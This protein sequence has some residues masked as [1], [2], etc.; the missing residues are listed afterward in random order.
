MRRD[1]PLD[2]LGYRSELDPTSL[3]TTP[4]LAVSTSNCVSTLIITVHRLDHLRWPGATSSGG[5]LQPISS[6][7]LTY[8]Q[9][10]VHISLSQ[11][12]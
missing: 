8:M 2:S 5:A 10:Y 11:A 9:V 12:T 4:S 7:M 3:T 6:T 1:C